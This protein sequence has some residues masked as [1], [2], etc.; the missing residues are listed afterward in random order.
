M[1]EQPPPHYVPAYSSNLPPAP[2]GGMA[3][4]SLVLGIVGLMAWF[5]PIIGLA[6][7]ITG[8]VLG[9]KSLRSPNRGMA[10]AGVVMCTLGLIASVVNGAVGAYLGATG[11]HSLINRALG[12]RPG[13]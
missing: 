10:I 4:A 3:I 1:S 11:Q 5:C 8:L 9:C 6:V 13:G 2:G 12:T 7:N